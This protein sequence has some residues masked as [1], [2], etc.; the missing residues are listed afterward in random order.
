MAMSLWPQTRDSRVQ[1]LNHYTV[2]LYRLV[3]LF[4]RLDICWEILITMLLYLALT[5]T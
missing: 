1:R 3:C 5:L 2:G 4:G